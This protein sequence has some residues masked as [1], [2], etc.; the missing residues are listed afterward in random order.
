[1][2]LGWQIAVCVSIAVAGLVSLT[3][4]RVV[5]IGW[6]LWTLTA[7]LPVFA[8]WVGVFQ[9]ANIATTYVVISSRAE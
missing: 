7:V 1:M 5:V 2:F 6:V 4:L 3:A 9:L 8:P